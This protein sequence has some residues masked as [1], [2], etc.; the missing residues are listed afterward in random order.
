MN[1]LSLFSGIGGIDLAAEWAGMKTVAF[2]EREPFPQKVLKKHW[3]NVPLYDDVK[4]LTKAR[5]EADG[6]DTRTIGL[7]SAGYPCQP[8]SNAGKRKGK[9]DDRHLW[10]FVIKLIHEI[11]PRWFLGENV[12]GHIS[13]GLD[14][15]LSDLADADYTAQAFVIPAAAVYA[16]HRRDRVFIVGYTERSGCGGESRGGTEQ[17]PSNG[18]LQHS[19]QDVANSSSSRQPK[20]HTSAVTDRSGYSSG[21]SN[22]GGSS[23]TIES[24]VGGILDGLSS[25]LDSH[26]WPAG[27]GQDQYDWESPRVAKGI[28]YRSSRLKGLGNAV[29]PVQ[30]YPI[31]VA[32][33]E[34][35]DVH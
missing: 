31:M 6:I 11:R 1:H 4:T 14:D 25:Q 16:P 9:T 24:G 29:N 7:I 17:E 32:I 3:P 10:P 22:A 35:D 12:A 19:T 20:F 13:L 27:L 18:H 26:K 21:G 15:V 30:I 33:K 5:F 23:G 34:I 8:F 2:C 28:K